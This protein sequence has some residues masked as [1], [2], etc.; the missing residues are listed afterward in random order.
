[1]CFD[2]WALSDVVEYMA[3]N[4]HCICHPVVHPSQTTSND[5]VTYIIPFDRFNGEDPSSPKALLKG[6]HETDIARFGPAVTLRLTNCTMLEAFGAVTRMSQSTT[7]I[8]KDQITISNRR[9]PP[10]PLRVQTGPLSDP[11]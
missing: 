10:P 3:M 7:K 4:L 6:T 5:A 1:M 9:R 8:D 2:G 11:F